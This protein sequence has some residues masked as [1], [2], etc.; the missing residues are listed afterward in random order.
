MLIMVI[1]LPGS[2]KSYFSKALAKAMG[3]VH[4]NSDIIR[5]S[6]MTVASYTPEDKQRVYKDMYNEVKRKLQQGQTVIVDATFSLEIYRSPYFRF[7]T[8]NKIPCRIILTEAQE[9]TIA[10][11]LQYKRPDSD[12]D[13]KVYLKIKSE[14]QPLM[15]KHLVLMTDQLTLVEM[16]EKSLDFIKT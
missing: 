16:I 11:R 6:L 12:A 5:K 10:S 4:I 9:D 2:G 3:G 15:K 13:F 14:F 1:G 7:A 8:E